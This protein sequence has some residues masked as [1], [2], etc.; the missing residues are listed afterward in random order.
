MVT[1]PAASREAR[2]RRLPYAE[3]GIFD[4]DECNFERGVFLKRNPLICALALSTRRARRAAAKLAVKLLVQV[5]LAGEECKGRI[6]D[7]LRVEGFDSFDCSE[8]AIGCLIEAI[9]LLEAAY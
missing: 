7:C 6:P 1:A 5:W 9:D 3:N 4:I 2:V 8:G